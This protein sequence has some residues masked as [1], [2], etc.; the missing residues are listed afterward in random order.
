MDLDKFY[1]ED[2]TFY[3]VIIGDFSAKI[4]P[5]RTPEEL[6]IE[7]HGLQWN[8]QGCHP[9]EC[10]VMKPHHRQQKVLVDGCRCCAKV[11]YGIGPS[12]PRGRFSFTRREEK[13]ARF[14]KRSPRTVIDCDLFGYVSLLLGRFPIEQH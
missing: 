10:T 2:H 12:T 8:E 9:V 11:L 3:K 7:T 4:V 6:R 5:R 13:G 14:R 1:R